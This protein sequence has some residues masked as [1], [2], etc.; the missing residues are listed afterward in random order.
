[1][2]CNI[3]DHF[4]VCHHYTGREFFLIT[5]EM[6]NSINFVFGDADFIAT[7]IRTELLD[8]SEYSR[9]SC[10]HAL[11]S[12]NLKSFVR[13]TQIGD[14][15]TRS[16]LV[17]DDLHGL[18]AKTIRNLDFVF[19]LADHYRSTHYLDLVLVADNR[20]L[21]DLSLGDKSDESE[22][23]LAL[24]Q[25]FGSDTANFNGIAFSGRIQRMFLSQ[26]SNNFASP[27]ICEL[28]HQNHRDLL[29]VPQR[30]VTV[31][32]F[33]AFSLLTRPPDSF[34][35]ALAV[36]LPFIILCNILSLFKYF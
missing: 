10:I 33:S 13:K 23:R 29:K 36:A 5:A 8:V 20:L 16:L 12:V 6:E 26:R 14:K 31:K 11:D 7:T 32:V 2:I 9:K 3:V 1:M 15:G 22:W 21:K 35:F 34:Q 28:L 4:E 17:V 25:R 30:S 18:D 27:S 19:Q 24:A